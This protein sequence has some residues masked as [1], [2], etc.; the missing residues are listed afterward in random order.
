MIDDPLTH[1][2]ISLKTGD[3]I[4]R[5]GE[6]V[7]SQPENFHLPRLLITHGT[8]DLLTSFR[9]SEAFFNALTRRVPDK[10][11]IC[12]EGVYHEPHNDF[13]SRLAYRNLINWIRQGNS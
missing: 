11:F 10:K 1:T 3:F 13:G 4:L 9:A 6:E 5:A 2:R 12:Y 7:S 8:E